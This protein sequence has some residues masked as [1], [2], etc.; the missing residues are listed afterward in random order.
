MLVK[1]Y[2][3]DN[4]ADSFFFLTKQFKV[5]TFYQKGG[6]KL[7]AIMLSVGI[8]DLK[9]NL[10][11]YLSHVKKGEDVYITER[12]KVIARIIQEEL[13]NESWREAL[14]PLIAKGLL[15]LPSR[16][17]DRDVPPPLEVPGKPV[18]EMAIEDRR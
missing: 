6:H 10:S 16:K 2:G 9:D 4:L 14:G 5:A 12:G 17:I 18:S 3:L 11:R 8:K 1:S 13:R 15:T 7:G